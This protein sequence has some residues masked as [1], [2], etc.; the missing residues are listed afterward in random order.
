PG[1]AGRSIVAAIVAE[2][3]RAGRALEMVE[4]GRSILASARRGGRE[5]EAQTSIKRGYLNL[6]HAREAIRRHAAEARR[7]ELEGPDREFRR[8]VADL[9]EREASGGR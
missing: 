2:L 1:K 4:H 7:L 3:E 6:L 8:R 5:L 9:L